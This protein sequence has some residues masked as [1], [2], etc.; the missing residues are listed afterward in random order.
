MATT[1][2]LFVCLGN[3]CR[4]PL[5]EGILR[6]RLAEAGLADRFHVD[7]AGTADWHTG[8]PPDPRSQKVAEAH[9]ISLADQR[10]RPVAPDDFERFDWIVAMDRSNAADLEAMRSGVG[11]EARV[12]LLRDVDPDAGDGEVP[13]PYYGGPEGFDDVFRMVDRC[14]S[15]LISELLDEGDGRLVAAGSDPL[16]R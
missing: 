11:G 5:A 7:S 14:C 6:H 8:R 12:I 9:G 4:S 13:D 15:A 1:S 2:I 3:I 10:A 16:S